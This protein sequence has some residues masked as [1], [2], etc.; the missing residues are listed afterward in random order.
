MKVNVRLPS[1]TA[2]IGV[3]GYPEDGTGEEPL[4]KAA[5]R[6]L[7]KAKE[8]GRNRV[9]AARDLQTRLLPPNEFL[10]GVEEPL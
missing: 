6:A 7:Y 3:A 9:M 5:D 10:D 1:V 4:L 8:T 2:S